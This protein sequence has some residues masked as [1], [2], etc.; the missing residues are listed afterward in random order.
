MGDGIVDHLAS[1]VEC[2]NV[3]VGRRDALPPL[4]EQTN[5]FGQGTDE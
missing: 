5:E 4:V 3:V 2:I 1:D